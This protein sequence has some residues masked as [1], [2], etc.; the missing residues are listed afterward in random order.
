[1]NS[2][3]YGSSSIEEFGRF[4]EG[5]LHGSSESEDDTEKQKAEASSKEACTHPGSFQDMC[6]VCG[7]PVNEKDFGYEDKGLMLKNEEL[8]RVKKLGI[9]KLLHRKKL[10]L[11]V[12][13]DHTLLNSADSGEDCLQ[14]QTDGPQ[15]ACKALRPSVRSFLRDASYMYEMY[16]YTAG[17]RSYALEKG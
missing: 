12:D 10:Y 5:D 14:S 6:Y 16:M 17:E 7:L 3:Q 15:D 2:P 8:E 11:V 4:L 13:V 1:M 9:K